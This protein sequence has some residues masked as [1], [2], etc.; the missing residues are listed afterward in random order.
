MIE[1]KNAKTFKSVCVNLNGNAMSTWKM[2]KAAN[3]AVIDSER[4]NLQP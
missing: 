1:N 2:A 3:Q 4:I